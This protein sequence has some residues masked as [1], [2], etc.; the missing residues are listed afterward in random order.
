VR[1]GISLTQAGH[2]TVVFV[3]DVFER[4]ARA[5]A[6]ELG[7]PD[8]KI[9]VYPQFKPGLPDDAEAAKAEQAVR[10]LPALLEGTEEIHGSA[11]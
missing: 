9:H 1:D 4:A 2:P 11:R 6:S 3:H 10:E 7:L 8:L 5:Q